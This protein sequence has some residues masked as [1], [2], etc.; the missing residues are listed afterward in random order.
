MFGVFGV[1]GLVFGL[2]GVFGVGCLEFGVGMAPRQDDQ[3]TMA[4]LLYFGFWRVTAILSG[5]LYQVCILRH[6]TVRLSQD[7]TLLFYPDNLC[8]RLKDGAIRGSGMNEWLFW[9]CMA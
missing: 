5:L 2:F 3:R 6:E 8:L 1:G 4:C 7:L 9:H